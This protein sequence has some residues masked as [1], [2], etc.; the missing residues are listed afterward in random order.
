MSQV[1]RRFFLDTLFK[2]AVAVP[3]VGAGSS[4]FLDSTKVFDNSII[5]SDLL[6]IELDRMLPKLTT[7]FDNDDTFFRAIGGDKS[8]LMRVPIV[9]MNLRPG[10]YFDRP[11]RRN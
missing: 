9:R 7:L 8:F 3:L 2:T 5:A 4:V 6:A 1:T 11:N 10:G